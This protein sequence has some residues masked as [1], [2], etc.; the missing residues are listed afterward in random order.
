MPLGFHTSKDGRKMHV[1]LREDLE[2]LKGY[3]IKSPCIQIFVS[4]P[5]SFKETL[6]DE[7]KAG[8]RAIIRQENLP[9]CVHGAYVD[10]P[11]SMSLASI[12]NI[13]DEMKIAH[14]LGATGVIVHIGAGAAKDENLKFVLDKLA[15]IDADIKKNTILWLEIQTAKASPATV[16]TPTKLGILF[17]RVRRI[18]GNPAED[19]HALRVGLCIDSAHLFACGFAMDT[20]S[21]TTKWI[22]DVKKVLPSGTPIMMHLNDS[23]STLGSGKDKHEALTKGK[24]WNQ[25]NI[26]HGPLKIE[27]SGLI[28]ILEWAETDDITLIL[29]RNGDGIGNDLALVTTLGFFV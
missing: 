4:G 15:E 20:H 24:I 7:E 5:Q 11:W 28:A 27:D 8:V 29:E 25:Y 14:Q 21:V 10:N 23:G 22:N 26:D 13:K 9:L 16:E 3:G 1:A 17:D 12:Q 19:P 6:S 18:T 2:Y